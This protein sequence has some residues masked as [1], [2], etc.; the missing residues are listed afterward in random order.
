MLDLQN[1]TED[2]KHVTGNNRIVSK[3]RFDCEALI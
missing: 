1:T 2:Y 3:F